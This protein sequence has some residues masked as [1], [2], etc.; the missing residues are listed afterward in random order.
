MT[1]LKIEIHPDRSALV[2]RSQTLV[3]ERI[4]TA[5]ADR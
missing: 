2:A 5:I 3:I 1:A 4:R